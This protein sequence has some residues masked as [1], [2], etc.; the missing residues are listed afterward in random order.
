M[1]GG[2]G[3]RQATKLKNAC[4]NE[5]GHICHL[6]LKAGADTADHLIPRSKGGPNTIENVRPA[7]HACNSKRGAQDLTEWFKKHP[8][9]L[10]TNAPPSREW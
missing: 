7:H 4:L 9:T 6:C 8:P 10:H 3:G 5:Y 1:S 2:W